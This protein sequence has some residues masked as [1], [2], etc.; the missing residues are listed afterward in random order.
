MFAD[1]YI[2]TLKHIYTN[3]YFFVKIHKLFAFL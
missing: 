1:V 2:K 3:I